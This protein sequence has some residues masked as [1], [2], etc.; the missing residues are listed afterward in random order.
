MP[1]EA[2][3]T[4]G[5]LMISVWQ[6]AHPT[7][8]LHQIKQIL[9]VWVQMIQ[10]DSKYLHISIVIRTIRFKKASTGVRPG[11][12]PETTQP[13]MF[14]QEQE[15]RSIMALRVTMSIRLHVIIV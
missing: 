1:L 5:L 15:P 8:S 2:V 6:P 14:Q 12:H 4:T 3:A 9:C 11:H 7:C 13:G 10:Y